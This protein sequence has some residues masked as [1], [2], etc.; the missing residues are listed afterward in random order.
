MP[1][2]LQNLKRKYKPTPLKRKSYDK[3]LNRILMILNRIETQKSVKISELAQEFNV[4][5]RTVQRDIQKIQSAGFPLISNTK[6]SYSPD[7]AFSLKKAFL[8]S[9]EFSAIKLFLEMAKK[10]GADFWGIMEKTINNLILGKPIDSL[11]HILGPKPS[12]NSKNKLPF[13]NEITEAISISQKL[14]VEYKSNKDTARAVTHPL[15]LVFYEGDWYLLYRKEKAES[16]TKLRTLSLSKII[17]VK[18][19]DEYFERPKNLSKILNNA[20]SIWFNEKR[21]IKVLLELSNRIKKYFEF[22]N[23]F[24]CQKIVQQKKDSF[25]I[26]TRVCEGSD[27]MEIVP[28]IMRFIPDIKVIKP[29]DLAESIQKSVQSYLSKINPE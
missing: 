11:F 26:E 7:T 1:V 28:V 14:Q 21:K 20:T 13:L 23:Y 16:R 3:A 10:L 8:D 2:S 6:G 15:S 18:P 19:I 5:V 9:K 17:S 22:Q 4:S 12:K 27:F 29:R 24:P 25:V